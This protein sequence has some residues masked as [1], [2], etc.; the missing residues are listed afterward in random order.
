M[1]VLVTGATGF[2]G[3]HVAE[4][5]VAKGHQV[6][7]LV[8]RSSKTDFLDR[9]GAELVNAS[10]EE[11]KG[12]DEAV[13]GVDAIVHGAAI[14]KAR[15][16]EEFHYVN[17]GGTEHLIRAARGLGK[18]LRRFVYVSSLAAHGF[19]TNGSPRGFDEPSDPPT[20]YGKS[21]LAGEK[22]VL[23]HKD[24]I[25]V[26]IIRPPAIYGP[27]D[28]EMLAFFKI[29]K[30]RVV[31]FLGNPENRCSLIHASDCAN[32]IV[33]AIEKDHPSGRIY[34]VEDGCVY[35]Q[36]EVIAHIET[37]LGKRV[38]ARFPVPMAAVSVAALGS[39]LFGMARRQ[40]VMLTRDKV[41]ELRA[42][43]VIAPANAIREELGWSPRVT[44]GD[45]ARESVEW[46]R[47]AGLL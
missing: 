29:V 22:V 31:P 2:L 13:K 4:Q 46:Y 19:G 10:L 14:V 45:G 24:E 39:E 3:S 11:G 28:S 25:P 40:A 8:R 34:S 6:R 5:L 21:K 16:P 23:A 7:A 38:L 15:R 41:N 43:Q 9:L 35:T 18:G 37:A 42:Q 27:R 17:T 33:L 36:R 12:L 44:F 20:F 32:A 26:T 30:G 47:S 1:K